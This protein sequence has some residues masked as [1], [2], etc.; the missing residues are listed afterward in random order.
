MSSKYDSL[1]PAQLEAVKH[2]EGPLLILAGA[3]SGKTRVLTH[4]IAYLIEE[5]GVRPWN[6][7]AITFTNKAADEMRERVDRIVGQGAE[8]VWVATFHSSCVRILRRFID[9]PGYTTDFTI[10]DSD[11]QK[12]VIKRVVKDMN[13][14]PKNFPE[15]SVAAAI[16]SAKNNGISPEEMAKSN[17]VRDRDIAKIFVRYEKELAKNNALD[18]DDLLLKT[19]ELLKG[20]QDILEYYQEKFQFIMVDEYQDT[21][22]VQFELIKLLAG[23]YRNICVVG[24]DDQS[25][26]RFRGADIRNILDFEKIYPDAVVIKLEQNYRSTANILSAANTVI[27]NNNGRKS[28][29]LWT[30]GEAGDKV[31]VRVF[32]NAYDEAN[33]VVDEIRARVKDGNGTFQDYAILYRTNNQS[34]A[35]EE[36]CISMNIP[37]RIFGGLNFYQRAEIKDMLAYLKTIANGRDDLAVRR[38]INVPKRGIGQTTVDKIQAY[39]NDM[40]ITFFDAL[41]M[42]ERIPGMGRSV[43]KINEFTGLL[44]KLRRKLKMMGETDSDALADLLRAVYSETG[45]AA[46][47][48]E[49]DPASRETKQQ[50]IEEL[51]N[52]AVDFSSEYL[53]KHDVNAAVLANPNEIVLDPGAR[54]EEMPQ[55]ILSAFLEEVALVSDYDNL[56]EEG[57]YV[58]MMTIHGAKGLEFP[59]VYLVGMEEELFPSAM[60]MENELDI[61]E[62]RRLCYV[63]ITRAKK[64]LC[65]TAAKIRTTHGDTQFHAISRFVKELPQSEIDQCAVEGGRME[66]GKSAFT[67]SY[68]TKTFGNGN[69]GGSGYGEAFRQKPI[70]QNPFAGNSAA[71]PT[72]GK[73]FEP[74][75]S[76]SVDYGPGDRVSHVKFGAGTVLSV[77]EGKKDFEVEVEFD[78]FGVKRM[79]A[80]FAKL[81][82]L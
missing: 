25:I 29:K 74:V 1:N 7:M 67:G 36:K 40:N 11:D 81:K 65:L 6:I 57:G 58:C 12:N 39:A 53:S 9:L 21:N 43:A 22:H 24:D 52:K 16:S 10:Y 55:D 19:V 26:Y 64:N 41:C 47:L 77:T 33:A 42:V 4:R 69:G 45:Y 71:K 76:Q 78:G 44:G 51:I 56:D 61:E 28:K 60:S 49:L 13:L 72:F 2:T 80:A 20:N 70:A 66:S 46:E 18:F 34:R 48:N 62:E 8:D 32:N 17:N 82:K 3:G 79:F 59:N 63:G 27:K 35:F 31:R 54:E 30:Q 50:N 38:I 14:D 5:E 68:G 75:K 37:Y 73:A 23:G 15:R